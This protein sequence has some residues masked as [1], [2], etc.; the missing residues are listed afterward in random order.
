MRPERGL[1]LVLAMYVAVSVACAL[2]GLAALAYRTLGHRCDIGTLG[3][4]VVLVAASATATAGAVMI[5]VVRRR[6]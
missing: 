6:A 5:A 1:V 3:P 4:L 2:L